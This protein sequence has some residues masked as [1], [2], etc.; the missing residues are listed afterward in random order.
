MTGATLVHYLFLIVA[1][2]CFFMA[3]LRRWENP[4][5]VSIGWLGACFVVLDLLIFSG[6]K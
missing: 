4:P 3:F 2:V 5:G 6:A 1:L